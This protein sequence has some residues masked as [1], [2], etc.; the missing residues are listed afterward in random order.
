[1]ADDLLNSY[2]TAKG[3]KIVSLKLALRGVLKTLKNNEFVA[4]LS[5]QDAHEKGPL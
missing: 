2:R 3:I 1:M 5:D 4:I